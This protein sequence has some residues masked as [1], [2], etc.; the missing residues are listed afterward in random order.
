MAQLL[1]N[2]ASA[3]AIAGASTSFSVGM[4]A[5]IDRI[6]IY[7]GIMPSVTDYAT[8]YATYDAQNLLVSFGSAGSYTS[9]SAQ[10]YK[11]RWVG[12]V[13]STPV[14]AVATGTATWFAISS[15]S[16]NRTDVSNTTWFVLGTVGNSM[17]DADLKIPS[18]N[19]VAGDFYTCSGFSFSYPLI[20][21]V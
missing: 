8:N 21:E 15:S 6:Y 3:N 19:I 12:G 7:S 13:F 10:D 4:L 16:T 9:L 18:V 20:H 14:A 17:S 11:I 1:L 5:D 2:A